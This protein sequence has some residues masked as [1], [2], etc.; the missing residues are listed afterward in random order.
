MQRA[1]GYLGRSA[2]FRG[3]MQRRLKEAG[4]E[5]EEEEEEEEVVEEIE[6]EEEEGCY[7]R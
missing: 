7:L 6:E 3:L 5:M 1:A 2:E 4:E